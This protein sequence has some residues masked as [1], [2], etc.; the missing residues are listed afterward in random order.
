MNNPML[1]TKLV[2]NFTKTEFRADDVE[3]QYLS[4]LY[5]IDPESEKAQAVMDNYEKFR[6]ARGVNQH[7]V[8]T[9]IGKG[10]ISG[11][12]SLVGILLIIDF[13][14]EGVLTSKAIQFIP[15][16]KIF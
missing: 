6:K 16:P 4:A 7:P 9:E 2:S 3:A 11:A 13:E 10:I 14:K 5:W 1:I 8:F 12:I 15:K